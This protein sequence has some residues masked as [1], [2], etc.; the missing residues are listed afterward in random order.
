MTEELRERP[1][2][3]QRRMP[4]PAPDESV[5]PVDY[6]P[7]LLP[8]APA[9]PAENM[10]ASTPTVAEK[11]STQGADAAS[12][13]A[14]TAAVTDT[15]TTSPNADAKTARP[16]AAAKS[17]PAPKA[18]APPRAAR[19]EVT[20]PVSTRVSQE[21]LDLLYSAVESEG[22]SVRE[23]IEQGIRARWAKS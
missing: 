4:R 5:D 20:Y 12:E 19:R 9:G 17:K 16:K 6:T 2:T 13:I 8:T 15:A 14:E 11:V 23:A 18:P 22:I 7:I 10:K 21:I 1:A 3:L